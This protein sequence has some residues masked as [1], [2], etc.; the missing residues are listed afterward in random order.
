MEIQRERKLKHCLEKG[1]IYF[2]TS[3]TKDKKPI[4]LG[5]IT[6]RFFTITI[7]Y[8]KFALNFLLFG[9]VVM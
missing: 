9:Y 5:N 1:A 6:A 3:V 7:A 4:F 8:H 2:V